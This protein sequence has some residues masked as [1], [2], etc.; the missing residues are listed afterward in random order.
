MRVSSEDVIK[1]LRDV[2]PGPIRKHAVKV[3]G[4]AYPVK[5]AFAAATGVD[6]LDFDTNQARHW[7]QRLGFEVAR[8]EEPD[9]RQT[10]NSVEDPP[11][12]PANRGKK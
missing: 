8:V 11:K 4:V 12:G 10:A 7:F 6:L 5:Q 3:Q 2:T 1:R 9:D